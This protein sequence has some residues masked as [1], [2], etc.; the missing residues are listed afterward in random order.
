MAE[1]ELKFH[2]IEYISPAVIKAPETDPIPLIFIGKDTADGIEITLLDHKQTNADR[3]V[4]IWSLLKNTSTDPEY[5][6][7]L[8]T[9]EKAGECLELA[10]PTVSDQTGL[11]SFLGFSITGNNCERGE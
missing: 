11:P 6:S 7:F 10:D 9:I 5:S 4:Q 2:Q 8:K 3:Y 1:Q